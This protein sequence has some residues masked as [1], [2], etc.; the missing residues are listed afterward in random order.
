[1]S[2]SQSAPETGLPNQPIIDK[3]YF[4]KLAVKCVGRLVFRS[5]VAR[6]VACLLDVDPDIAS[7]SCMA[8][9][10]SVGIEAHVPD[11]TV[12]TASGS[13]VLI[14]APDRR[15]GVSPAA[16]AEAALFDNRTFRIFD[17]AELEHGHRL[18]N[19]KDLLRYGN[20]RA[21]LGDRVRL[22]AALEEY[23]SLTVSECL[24]VFK[25]T[26]PMAGLAALALHGYIEIELDEGP[27][28]PETT[29]RRVRR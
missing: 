4:P 12:T 21:P 28:G 16:I 11:F 22:L 17:V 24:T 13:T 6:D 1:M 15:P 18:A 23:G 5:Q 20:H 7:W 3:V 26:A 29:V 19:A 14:D 27:I 10:L 2:V 9:T 8:T 25:E